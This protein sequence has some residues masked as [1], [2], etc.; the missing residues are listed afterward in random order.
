MN[1]SACNLTQ[2]WW[3]EEK[4]ELLCANG[5]SMRG[6]DYEIFYKLCLCIEG[7]DDVGRAHYQD[8]LASLYPELILPISAENASRIWNQTAELLL[9]RGKSYACCPQN[10]EKGVVPI[11]R[12]ALEKTPRLETVLQLSD[13]AA[14]DTTN[15]ADWQTET[16]KQIKSRLSVGASVSLTLPKEFHWRKPNLY[17]VNRHLAGEERSTDLW[18]SQQLYFLFSL[19]EKQRFR[20]LLRVECPTDEVVTA[21]LGIRSF[22]VSAPIFY[23]PSKAPSRGD[24]L[25]LCRAIAWKEEGV[26]P[27]YL[28]RKATGKAE[29]LGTFG[30]VSVILRDP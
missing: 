17:E 14:S 3:D 29:F 19:A 10:A 15:W 28:V 5:F 27:L 22:G 12:L 4:E 25:K 18:A 16:E 11:T 26:R 13:F 1:R 9:E 30:D 8:A 2:Q 21:L 7:L 6:S 20:P 23:A 24:F